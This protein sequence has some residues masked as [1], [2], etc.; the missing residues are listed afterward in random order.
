MKIREYRERSG[1]TQE[2]LAKKMNVE[3]AAVSMWENGKTSPLRKYRKK[4]AKRRS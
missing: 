4:L 2:Q 1:M 3:Q